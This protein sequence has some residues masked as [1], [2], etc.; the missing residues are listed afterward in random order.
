MHTE[1]EAKTRWCPFARV[2]LYVRGD[3]P[4]LPKPVDLCGHGANKIL[5]DDPAL[6]A[7][8]QEAINRTG[9]TRCIGSGCMA[10]RWYDTEV[11]PRPRGPQ[12]GYCG[13][14]GRPS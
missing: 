6:T 13:L 14:A 1:E 9:A 12:R 3:A 7:S 4:D 11:P 2:T 10:W 5:T 8:I